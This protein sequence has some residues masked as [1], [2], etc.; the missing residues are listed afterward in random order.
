MNIS[1]DLMWNGFAQ[2]ITSAGLEQLWRPIAYLGSYGEL[3]S[4][5]ISRYIQQWTA[6]R[7]LD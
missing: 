6:R 5:K 1:Q 2:A 3:E 7:E 4:S